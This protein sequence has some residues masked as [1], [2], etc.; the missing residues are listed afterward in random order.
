MFD[1]MRMRKQME[2]DNRNG[3]RPIVNNIS[4]DQAAQFKSAP[5]SE[6]M[7]KAKPLPTELTKKIT[8]KKKKFV[9]ADTKDQIVEDI[10][11]EKPSIIDIKKALKEYTRISQEEYIDA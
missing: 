8:T 9:I 10:I 6:L 5:L 4:I 3:H 1:Q 11:D 2:I 7:T